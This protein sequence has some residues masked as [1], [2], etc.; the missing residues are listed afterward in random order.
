MKK[1]F[2]SLYGWIILCVALGGCQNLLDPPEQAAVP[3]GRGR[4]AVNIGVSA[5]SGS[6]RT[7][8]PDPSAFAKYTLSFSGPAVVDPVEATPG[9]AREVELPIGGWT[10]TATGYAGNGTEV[11]EGSAELTVKSGDNDGVDIILSPLLGIANGT[12]AYA[13]T[14]GN[15]KPSG[16]EFVISTVEG[17]IVAEI[18]LWDSP[19]SSTTS[20]KTSLAPGEYLVRIRL[21]YWSFVGLTEVLHIYSGL[22]TSLSREFTSFDYSETV[23]DFDLTGLVTAPVTWAAPVRTFPWTNQYAYTSGNAGTQV[24]WYQDTS[25]IIDSGILFAADTVYKAVV[26]LKTSSDM[27]SFSG[28]P[29]N[30]FEHAGA[31]LVVNNANSGTVTITFLPTAKDSVD[32][33]VLSPASPSLLQGGTQ[34]FSAEVTGTAAGGGAI[35]PPQTVSWSVSGNQSSGTFI[36]QD[37]GY[38]TVATDESAAALTV[39]ATPRAAPSQ[40]GEAMVSVASGGLIEIDDASKLAKIGVDSAY[41]LGGTYKLTANVTLPNDWT[42]LGSSAAPFFGV[43][44]GDNKKI[45]AQGFSTS[46]NYKGIFGYVKGISAKAE[47]KNLAIESSVN[48]STVATTTSY[49]GLLVAYAENAEISGITLSGSFVFSSQYVGGIVGLLKGSALENSSSSLDMTITG[50]SSYETNCAGGFVGSMEGN[51]E[52]LNC[53]NTGAV[54]LTVS[55]SNDYC[56]GIFG[57]YQFIGSIKIE[58]CSS[59]GAIEALSKDSSYGDVVAGG[60]AGYIQ[61]GS[62][63]K[64]CWA[65]GNVFASSEG[66]FGATGGGIAGHNSAGISQSYFNGTVTA[67]GTTKGYAGGIAGRQQGTIEDCWS[68]GQVTGINAAG[69]IVGV[70]RTTPTFDLRRSYSTSTITLTDSAATIDGAGGIV[71]ANQTSGYYIAPIIGCVALNSTVS[72]GA[73]AVMHRVAGRSPSDGLSNNYAWSG[74]TVSPGSGD[75]TPDIGANK[76]DGADAGQLNQAFYEGLGW[77]F[78]GIWAMDASGYPKLQWQTTEISRSPLQ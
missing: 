63:I 51:V 74:M 10:I 47:L 45:T 65:E 59:T 54:G 46:G 78:F 52:I 56:G 60:I 20:W 11:A 37:G 6:A 42:P 14:R 50:R 15:R 48:S 18:E 27:F 66:V 57:G 75:Y 22:T 29:S 12:F 77:D 13:I 30:R 58:G 43:F 39:R 19:T 2:Q 61:G 7:L 38:L 4:V 24:K 69:G 26:D 41:P 21:S 9:V 34:Q 76:V 25:E 1:F 36:T 17:E 71:G 33:I 55:G 68:H 23:T 16:R 73:G 70:M 72:G 32:A 3:Q 35:I 67:T 40:Y 5:A 49:A 44:D 62:M 8:A 28:V 53:H 64:N 31:S